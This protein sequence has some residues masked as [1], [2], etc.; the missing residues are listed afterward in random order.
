MYNIFNCFFRPDVIV[1]S[2][3]DLRNQSGGCSVETSS[4]DLSQSGGGLVETSS[5][6][7]S[8]SG[9]GSVETSDFD[10]VIR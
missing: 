6:D 4:N 1:G 9:D 8:Q 2:D 5:N 7:L 10:G 3:Y